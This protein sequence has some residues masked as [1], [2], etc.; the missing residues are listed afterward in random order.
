MQVKIQLNL[1]AADGTPI[2]HTIHNTIN[3]VPED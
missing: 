1:K 2:R 3:R